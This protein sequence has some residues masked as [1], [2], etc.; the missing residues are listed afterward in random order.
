MKYSAGSASVS[1]MQ[2]VDTHAHLFDEAFHDDFH[3]VVRRAEN[4]GIT[5]T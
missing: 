4:A 1:N 2:Y 3:D 5:K